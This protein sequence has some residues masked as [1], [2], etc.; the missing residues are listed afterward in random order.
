L[1]IFARSCVNI[2]G[3][4]VTKRTNAMSPDM[5]LPRQ[6]NGGGG[7]QTGG[8]NSGTEELLK[9]LSNPFASQVGWT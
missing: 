8:G 5:L 2:R 7:G 1:Q 3:A 4:G 9:L 6:D